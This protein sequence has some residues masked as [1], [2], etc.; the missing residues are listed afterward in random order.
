MTCRDEDE[1][2]L[3]VGAGAAEQLFEMSLDNVCVAGF[4]G[5][6]KRV[7]PSWT[8]TLGWTADELLAKPIIEFVHPEDRASVFADRARLM[9]GESL[10]SMINRYQ[11]KDGSYRWFEWRSVADLERE[12]VYAVARDITEQKRA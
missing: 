2:K 5:Y 4:D 12:R 9:A 6:F 1:Q 11:C 3:A 8:R 10:G 7:N